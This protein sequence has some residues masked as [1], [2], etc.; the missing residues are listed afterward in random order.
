MGGWVAGLHPIHRGVYAVG[1]R[2]DRIQSRWIAAV[3]M[4]GPDAVLS[5]RSAAQ[6]WRFAPRSGHAVEV[7][8]P[9]RL[10]QHPHIRGHRSRLSEDERTVI[11][12]IPVTTAPRTILDLAAVASRR[13]VE[14]ALNEMEAQRV[15][16]PLS[17]LTT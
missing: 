16:D 3:L 17:I 13:E 8:R 4:A 12:G 10:R 9:N 6:L 15:T 14:R 2:S 7:T 11:D 5:H 1:Y